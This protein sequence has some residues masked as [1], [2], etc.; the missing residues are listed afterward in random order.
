MDGGEIAW[1]APLH[2]KERD[3]SDDRVDGGEIAWRELRCMG[4]SEMEATTRWTAPWGRSEMEATTGWTEG[5]PWEIARG[6]VRGNE[7]DGGDD[8][9]ARK[10]KKGNSLG[11]A[12]LGRS[13]MEATTGWTE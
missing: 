6:K 4:R 9:G 11:K 12:P 13:K 7:R 8:I 5:K 10:E 1:R 3:G 2:G